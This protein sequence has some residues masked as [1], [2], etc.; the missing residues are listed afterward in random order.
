MS[1]S[2]STNARMKLSEMSQRPFRAHTVKGDLDKDN[3]VKTMLR[4]DI[5]PKMVVSDFDALIHG[6]TI[7]GT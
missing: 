7:R 4:E 5:G 3:S 1:S 2:G 6:C